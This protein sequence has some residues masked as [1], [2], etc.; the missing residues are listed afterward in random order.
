MFAP[1]LVTNFLPIH[2]YE[3]ALT[4]K[5]NSGK[6]RFALILTNSY[7]M[8]KQPI[9]QLKCKMPLSACH[10]L[11]NGPPQAKGIVDKKKFALILTNSFYLIHWKKHLYQSYS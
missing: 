4:G 9:L 5:G 7:Y 3:R 2:T 11:I 1:D 10:A 6:K 8:K